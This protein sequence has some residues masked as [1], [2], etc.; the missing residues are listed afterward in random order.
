MLIYQKKRVMMD[1]GVHSNKSVNN[2]AIY[3]AV[4]TSAIASATLI[5]HTHTHIMNDTTTTTSRSEECNISRENL[6]CVILFILMTLFPVSQVM[7]FQLLRT[8][9][10]YVDNHPSS[11]SWK[12]LH[13]ATQ[14]TTNVKLVLI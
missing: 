10:I 3:I 4:I 9:G 2:L 13:K 12:S 7:L 6:N 11:I 1:C 8:L 14:S 5:L